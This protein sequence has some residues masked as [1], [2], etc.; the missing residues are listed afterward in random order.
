MTHSMKLPGRCA[1]PVEAGSLRLGLML[2]ALL[3]VVLMANEARADTCQISLSQPRLDYGHLRH[4]EQTLGTRTLHLSIVCAE[5]SAMA[6]RFNGV[7]AD[8][9]GFRFGRQG[10]FRLSLQQARIDGQPVEWMSAPLPG[11]L[12]TAPLVPGQTLVA[13]ASGRPVTGRR[14]T[15]QVEVS[16]EVPPEAFAVRRETLLEGLGVFERVSPAVP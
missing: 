9:R 14:L 10:H 6:L 3:A 11:A 4:G 8:A 2:Y 12:A 1:V 13:S 7:A 15:A 16:A 5:P